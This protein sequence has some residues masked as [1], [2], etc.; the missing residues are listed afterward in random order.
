MKRLFIALALL[1][2]ADQTAG[3]QGSPDPTFNGIKSFTVVLR[4]PSLVVEV[5]VTLTKRIWSDGQ[6]LAAPR[7]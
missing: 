3:A 6:M 5:I 4:L 2:L 1:T 7:H